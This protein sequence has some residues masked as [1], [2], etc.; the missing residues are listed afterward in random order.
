[1]ELLRGVE[2]LKLS[3]VNQ[4]AQ[5]WIEQDYH[6]R[7]HSEIKTTPLQRMLNGPDVARPTP[8]SDFLRL[9]FT[10]RISRIP[11]RSDAT[12]VVEGIRYELPARFGHL[13]SV[14]L[15]TPSW[16]KSQMTLVD[17]DT[18][19]ALARL[20][21]QDK[22]KNASGMRRAI[23]PDNTAVPVAHSSDAPLPALLRKWLADY[24]ATGLPPAYLPKEEIT[25]E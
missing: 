22:V 23:H 19:A 16:D 11:R 13:R 4:A 6:R 24:A 17:P 15:R 12:V 5:A 25:H 7:V 18:D 2:N 8:D 10:R 14:I 3:F 1:M 20:L 9:A 21:P